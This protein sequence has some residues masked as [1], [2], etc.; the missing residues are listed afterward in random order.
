MKKG[1]KL[2]ALTLSSLLL[3]NLTTTA[4]ANQVSSGPAA[5]WIGSKVGEGDIVV[6]YTNDVHTHIDNE[7]L[8]YSDVAAMKKE[9]KDAGADV[10]LVDAGDHVQG[11]A[12]GSMDKGATIIS[13]MNAAGYD[14]ATL[15]NHE[16]DYGMNGA[17]DVIEW[18][19]FPYISANFYHEKDGTQT[20]NVLDSFKVFQK[21]MFSKIYV[22]A[23]VCGVILVGFGRYS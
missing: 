10:L 16:F 3:L 17:M 13:L 6:L 23:Y 19:K 4:F 2:Q 1:R 14:L 7:G 15:G 5:N 21:Y 9:L 18:A 20:G 11:T 22:L 8:R 12:F